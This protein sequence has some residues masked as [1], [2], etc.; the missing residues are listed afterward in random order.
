MKK[1]A[2]LLLLAW[3]SAL[4][5]CNTA[6][7]PKKDV[8]A[9]GKNHKIAKHYTCVMDADVITDK[10]GLCPKCGMKLVEKNN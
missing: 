2:I 6:T 3:L 5:A 4:T 1:Y 10:P 7:D 8:P 9:E